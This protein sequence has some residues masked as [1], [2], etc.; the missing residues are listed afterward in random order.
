MRPRRGDLHCAVY[1]HWWLVSR[2]QAREAHI[3][4]MLLSLGTCADGLCVAPFAETT[5]EIDWDWVVYHLF[6]ACWWCLCAALYQSL[7][8]GSAHKVNQQLLS[9]ERISAGL[10]RM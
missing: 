8:L 10:C 9:T 4:V 2:F 6:S 7:S 5:H 3:Q 1:H